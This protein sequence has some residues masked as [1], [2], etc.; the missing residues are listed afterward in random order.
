M[1][2]EEYH[3]QMKRGGRASV[4]ASIAQSCA[5]VPMSGDKARVRWTKIDVGDR[6]SPTKGQ[7]N[8]NIKAWFRV[9]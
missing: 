8:Q 3:A 1:L 9:Q 7:H 5:V 2:E 6:V 4:P